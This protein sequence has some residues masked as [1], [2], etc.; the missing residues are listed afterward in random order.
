MTGTNK[1]VRM[2]KMA[3]MEMDCNVTVDNLE[4]ESLTF[5]VCLMS[6][7]SFKFV[8]LLKSFSKLRS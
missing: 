1:E 7:T 6:N 5:S 3:R 2:F 8:D 4:I